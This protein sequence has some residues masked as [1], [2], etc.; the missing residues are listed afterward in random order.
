MKKC[1]P[2]LAI[3]LTGCAS[4]K[5]AQTPTDPELRNYVADNWQSYESQLRYMAQAP[6]GALEL[7]DVRGV[8]CYG[9]GVLTCHF[10]LT[11]K[12]EAG[13]LVTGQTSDLFAYQDGKL[14]GG[15]IIVG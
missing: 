11:A 1:A 12:T 13:Q 8:R 4:I 10:T 7:V 9:R 2:A 6:A 5:G 15:I 14:D 3:S